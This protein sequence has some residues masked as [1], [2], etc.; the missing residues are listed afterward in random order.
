[1]RVVVEGET[2]SDV[3]SM[4]CLFQSHPTSDCSR[5]SLLYRTITSQQNHIAL[6]NDLSEL[7]RWAEKWG[8]RFNANK[9][10]VMSVNCKSTHFYTLCDHI[11]KQ[12]E[13]NP[14][15][16]LTLTEN[17]K[18]SS[19]ITKITKKANTTLNFLR[20]NL[21]NFPQECRKTTYI[22]FVRLILDYG[23]IVWDPYLKQDID[24]LERVQ[25]QAAR[26]ITGDYRSREEG[27]VTGMF[28][29]LELSSLENRRSSNRLIFMYKIVEGLVPA[30][31]PNEFLKPA[32]QNRQVK[33]K[34]FENCETKNI[35]DRHTSNNNRNF[36]VEHCKSEQ[37]KQSFFV[38]TIVEW[39]H[40][41]TATVRSETV[42]SFKQALS[43][44]Y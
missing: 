13:E 16:G 23:S 15:L 4:T 40:L 22:S 43:Q 21:K 2:S 7:E 42:E 8:M 25:V 33:E 18:W 1:M 6:Q 12:V 28:K 44:C 11:L 38:R 37:L 5:T 31:P 32:K 3:L 27:C 41:D 14:Y 17:L 34:N 24:K 9:C 20:R 19:H 30:I 39:N 35:L 26:F 10:Y 36:T 29:S